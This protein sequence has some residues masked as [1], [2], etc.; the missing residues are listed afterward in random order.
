MKHP[1]SVTV[2]AAL[3]FLV[4]AYLV[5]IG[6][7][8]FA[9]P[10]AL[11]TARSAGIAYGRELDGPQTLYLLAQDGRWSAGIYRLKIGRDGAR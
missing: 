11:A 1:A 3:F 4:A 10:G 5:V 7:V 9:V 2:I 6:I 8:E